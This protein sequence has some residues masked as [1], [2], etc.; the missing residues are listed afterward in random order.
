MTPSKIQHWCNNKSVV[1]KANGLDGLRTPADMLVPDADLI[2]VLLAHKD[3]Y[4]QSS[5]VIM[6]S[7]TRTRLHRKVRKRR[8]K[9]KSR[10]KRND[11]T[12]STKWR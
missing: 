2:L 12:P 8:N 11:A 7:H 1:N 4:S 3:G 9:N 6:A 10:N 5:H